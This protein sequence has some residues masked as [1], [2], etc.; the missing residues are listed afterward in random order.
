VV[1]GNGVVCIGSYAFTCDGEYSN[2]NRI[3]NIT[4][5]NSIK[6]IGDRAFYK[7]RVTTV[8]IPNSVAYIG[9]YAF[10]SY[11]NNLLTNITIGK[12]VM[13]G[14]DSDGDGPFYNSGKFDAFYHSNM[15]KAGRYS[16]ANGNWNYTP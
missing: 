5:G 11:D 10:L 13:F 3:T 9:L 14:L 16:F 8:V 12:Y 15:R 6:Y 7:H 4:L 2:D 1:I